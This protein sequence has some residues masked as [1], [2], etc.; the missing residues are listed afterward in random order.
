MGGDGTVQVKTPLFLLRCHHFS[1]ITLVL[2]QG[3]HQSLTIFASV[4]APFMEERIFRGPYS[5]FWMYFLLPA[6]RFENVVPPLSVS[7]SFM[8]TLSWMLMKVSDPESNGTCFRHLVLCFSVESQHTHSP[9][10]LRLCTWPVPECS[11]YPRSHFLAGFLLL[12]TFSPHFPMSLQHV[13]CSALLS[14]SKT[15]F[16]VSPF[17]L[18]LSLRSQ[19]DRGHW[20]DC[21]ITCFT[22]P[23]DY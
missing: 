11:R 16:V 13:S 19:S 1:W 17:V 14:E 6:S 15:S 5:S 23:S 2:L 4:L 18:V 3:N 20:E 9:S 12:D 7:G 21:P 8:A 22:L 10:S